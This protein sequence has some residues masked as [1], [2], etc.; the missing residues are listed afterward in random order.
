MDLCPL[1]AST[2]V[3]RVARDSLPEDAVIVLS[4]RLRQQIQDN[5]P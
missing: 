3:P 2:V 1:P 4:D 5:T